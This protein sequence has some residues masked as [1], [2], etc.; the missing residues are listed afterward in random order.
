[1][2]KLSERMSAVAACVTPG[3]CVADIGCD[4]GYLPIYLVERKIAPSA[5]AMDIKEG[6]LQAAREHIHRQGLEEKIKTRRS[7]GLTALEPGEAQSVIIAGMGGRLALK[8]VTDGEDFLNRTGDIREVIIQPQ[9]ELVL[10]RRGMQE[11]GFSCIQEDMVFE[12]GKFYPLGRYLPAYVEKPSGMESPENFLTID[13]D[14]A[15]EYGLWLL[16]NRHPILKQ[17]L[18]KE[19]K[20]LIQIRKS[21]GAMQDEQARQHRLQEVEE[22]MQKNERARSFFA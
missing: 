12:D 6:P 13:K 5:I 10:F 8:I 21:L 11:M 17:Y 19:A 14:L 18:E 7:D 3:L 20:Q 22:K 1:M 9:S 4:H 16:A 15:E 2:I